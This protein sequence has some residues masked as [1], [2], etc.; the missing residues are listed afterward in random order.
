MN[1]HKKILVVGI[2]ALGGV[3]SYKLIKEG[4]SCQLVSQ[5]ESIADMINR[6]GIILHDGSDKDFVM[7]KV[8]TELPQD[9]QF[10]FIF[11]MMKTTSIRVAAEEIK[12]NN[13][14]KENGQIVTIQNGD[15]YYKI[16]DLFPNQIVTCI[17][18]WGASMVSPG[19]Y[20]ITSP[21]KTVIGD[22][23][24]II[25]LNEIQMLLSKV[26]PNP[27][28]LSSN[29]LGVIWSKL[30]LN[31]AINAIS[32]ISGLKVG[33]YSKLAKA[34]ELFL[35]TYRESFEV[36][37]YLH[38]K[39]EKLVIKPTLFYIPKKSHFISKTV[40]TF[41]V[42]RVGKKFGLV[43][44]S[45][46][47]DLERGRKTEIDYLNGY[48]SEKGKEIGYP[49]PVNDKLTEIIKLIEKGELQPKIENFDLIDL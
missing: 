10:D 22:R 34:R 2:G 48:V 44:T 42:K 38:I 6:N 45:M 30:C 21:G 13:L 39:L 7:A 31:C 41:F 27:V 43:K 9:E 23:N 26:S 5:N 17:I 3:F 40:K 4:Y 46:L 19:E 12:K 37:E 14:L 47:Q 24:D 35:A 29:I 15:I 1:L 32:G 28:E 16:S 20:R 11:L 33:E 25:D 49:T 8:G 36:S 18:V